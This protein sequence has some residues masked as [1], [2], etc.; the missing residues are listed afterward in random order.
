MNKPFCFV[1]MPFNDELSQVYEDA[2]KPAV[3]QAGLKCVRVD[4]IPGSGNIVRRIVESVHEAR[5][6]I[7]DLTGKNANV[8]YELGMA[9]AL[10]NNVIVLA[11]NIKEDVPFDV[12]TYKV[13]E[14][15]RAWGED[16]RL[17][18]KLVQAIQTLDEW[19]AHPSNPVQDFLPPEARPIPAGQYQALQQ[20]FTAQAQ[21]Q[22]ETQQQLQEKQQQCAAL[23]KEKE[24]LLTAQEGAQKQLEVAQQELAALRPAQAR[25]AAIQNSI[26]EMFQ[27]LGLDTPDWTEEGD[28]EQQWDEFISALS[29]RSPDDET[30][31]AAERTPRS[32]I[33]F[34][35]VN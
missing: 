27:S 18:E 19:G 5:I 16:R 24:T 17:R 10:G 21:A 7:A 28:F 4:E 6:I 32:R 33:T 35:K 11:Q 3:E 25:L 30:A 23:H 15:K 20:E 31:V 1:I 8:F 34:K 29:Q 9:H 14:Y 22:A 26:Q 13:I 2:I 12:H